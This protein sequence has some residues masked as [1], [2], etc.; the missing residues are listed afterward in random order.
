MRGVL[1]ALCTVLA[2]VP[3]AAAS[4][5][6]NSLVDRPFVRLADLFDDSGTQAERVLGPAPPPGGRYVV[7][8]PQLAAI[9]RQFGVDWHPASGADRVV[10]ER[11][12]RLLERE[13]VLKA[14]T[15]ALANA[16]APPDCQLTLAGFSAP[17]VAREGT[18]L[19]SVEQL[20]YDPSAGRFTATVAI[21]GETMPTQRLRVDGAVEAAMEVPVPVRRLEAGAVVGPDDLRL[22]RVR[23]S[24]LRDEVVR[25]A[26]Q[27]VGQTLRRAAAADMPVPVAALAHPLAVTKGASVIMTLQTPGLTILA[28]GQALSGGGVGE[29]VQVLNPSS[30]AVV[31]AEVT[32]ADQV[33][34][35][36]GSMPLSAG[37]TGGQP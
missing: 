16:G 27:A 11:P 15:A 36:P 22:E 24:L 12:G 20:D 9:A 13:A 5:R 2:A 23:A 34:V 30:H 19:V 3:A 6:P 33:R 32:G 10:V 37:T 7:P 4:L 8:A 25:S 21:S 35:R 18:P 28:R 1:L 26:S 17:L 14:L 31:E 29:L